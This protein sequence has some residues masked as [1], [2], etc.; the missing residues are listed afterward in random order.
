MGV[1]WGMEKLKFGD[2]YWEQVEP[3]GGSQEN[4]DSAGFD[5]ATC[6]FIERFTLSHPASL[7]AC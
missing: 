2:G 6:A 4:K 1:F 7:S 3:V 5:L